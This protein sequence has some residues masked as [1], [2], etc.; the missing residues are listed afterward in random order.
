MCITRPHPPG[1]P[2]ALSVEDAELYYERFG[3]NWERAALIKAR[4]IAGDA[5]AGEMLL[6]EIDDAGFERRA[7][8]GG[9]HCGRNGLGGVAWNG[10]WHAGSGAIFDLNSNALRPAGW[11]SADAAG[12][13]ILPGLV[14]YD[15]VAAGEIDGLVLVSCDPGDT[16][17]KAIAAA[18]AAGDAV[19]GEL[20]RI[21]GTELAAAAASAG[22]SRWLRPP[23]PCRPSKLRLLVLTAY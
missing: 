15:E 17:S 20:I 16:N 2:L 18:A 8:F 22:L 19:A 13:P 4:V 11:T 9:Q 21:A 23:G 12:L 6:P 7:D 10:S 5:A 3:Q 1:Q 14:R